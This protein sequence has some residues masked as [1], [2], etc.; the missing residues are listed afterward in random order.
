LA[1]TR[2]LPTLRATLEA[3]LEPLAEYQA[4]ENVVQ[5]AAR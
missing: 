2:T 4:P 5:L 3:K 1:L